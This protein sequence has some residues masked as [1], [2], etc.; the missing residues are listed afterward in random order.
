MGCG[1]GLDPP[2][3]SASV[4]M[5]APLRLPPS[6]AALACIQLC[7]VAAARSIGDLRLA[8]AMAEGAGRLEIYLQP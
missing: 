3:K 7:A 5:R 2:S 1:L 4:P 6:C 8:G